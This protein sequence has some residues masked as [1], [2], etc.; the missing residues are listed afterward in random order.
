MVQGIGGNNQTLEAL[1]GAKAAAGSV[2]V[3]PQQF[4]GLTAPKNESFAD[5]LTRKF[6]GNTV[7]GDMFIG[8]TGGV[9][10]TSYTPAVTGTPTTKTVDV[11]EF[12]GTQNGNHEV[13]AS[14]IAKAEDGKAAYKNAM[15]IN[16]DVKT[17]A[18]PEDVRKL[19]GN[20]VGYN[21]IYNG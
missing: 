17:N 1:Y 18:S 20:G 15:G 12:Y 21:I 7:N 4:L 5:R 2:H 3:Q 6:D 11:N 14:V 8:R 9:N 10:G 19:Q 16:D 13:L